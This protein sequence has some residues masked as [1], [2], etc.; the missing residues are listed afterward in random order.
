[1]CHDPLHRLGCR[2]SGSWH[3]PRPAEICRAPAAPA[4]G[5]WQSAGNRRILNEPACVLSQVGWF[6]TSLAPSRVAIPGVTS[7]A[8]SRPG[9]WHPET[10]PTS[11]GPD[12]G[13][14]GVAPRAKP[15]FSLGR[16]SS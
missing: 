1:M 5:T 2:Y 12:Q 15:V 11:N 8:G 6:T 10:W 4:G 3:V 7:Q 9:Q 14:T 13:T 16:C